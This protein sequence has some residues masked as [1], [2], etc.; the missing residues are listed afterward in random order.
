MV[1]NE[2]NRSGLHEHML[3]H[4]FGTKNSTSHRL[5]RITAADGRFSSSCPSHEIKFFRHLNLE[6]FCFFAEELELSASSSWLVEV[7]ADPILLLSLLFDLL[8]GCRTINLS[9]VGCLHVQCHTIAQFVSLVEQKYGTS[10]MKKTASHM[11]SQTYTNK[12][13]R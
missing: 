12:K 1:Q 2:I 6:L 5:H 9:M 11:K 8:F 13:W 7:L 3:Q 4:V 10:L